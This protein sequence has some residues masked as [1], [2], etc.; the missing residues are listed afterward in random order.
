MQFAAAVIHDPE[1]VVLDEPF[2][3]LDPI[4]SRLL[5]DL[6]LEQRAK[7]T[8]VIL[9]T[10]RMEEVEALCESICLIHHGRAV[11]NGRLRDIKARHGRHMIAVEHSGGPG[12]L[13]EIRGVQECH[14][15]GRE[16]RLRLQPDADPQSVMRAIFD[17]V[18]VSSV[19]L[20]EPRIEDIYLET[21][22]AAEPRS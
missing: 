11:L 19:R 1:L 7:G 12:R 5:K 8:T 15:G 9:S 17:R 16:V 22:N 3:G 21:V 18:E 13:N 20:D 2:S 4:N 6:I 14:D 10:H